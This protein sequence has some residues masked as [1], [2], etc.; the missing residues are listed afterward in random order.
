MVGWK[1]DHF[2]PYMLLILNDLNFIYLLFALVFF[3]FLVF[4]F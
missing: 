3:G 4:G 1:G 2:W